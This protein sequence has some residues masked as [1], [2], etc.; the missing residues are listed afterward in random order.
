MS[1]EMDAP[2]QLVHRFI[3]APGQSEAPVLLLLHGTGG[4]ED[5]L[6]ELG[7]MLYPG[8][9]RLSPRGQ[10]LENGMPR[11]FRRLAEG[12]FDQEDL[13]QRT[14]ELAEFVTAAAQHYDFAGRR[15]VAV[16]YSNG[17]NIAASMLLL[18]PEILAG[19]ELL[20]AMVPLQ[21]D[22]SPRLGGVRVLLANGKQDPLIPP[23]NVERLATIL[24]NAGAEV[25]LQWS[26]GGHQL[27]SAEVQAA[28]RWLADAFGEPTR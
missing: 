1:L 8:A 12:V 16:G 5:D 24:R 4:N 23:E 9:P 13:R 27:D 11:F 17:A 10:V 6:L 21:P 26:T 2:L 19:A 15:I 7:A 14:H 25:S 22:S 3:P 18:H 20:R 28:A